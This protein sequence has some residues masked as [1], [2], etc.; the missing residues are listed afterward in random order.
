[1]KICTHCK[2]PKH[3]DEF[4]WKN[5]SKGTKQTHCKECQKLVSQKWYIENQ[6]KHSE[7]VKKNTKLYRKRNRDHIWNYLNTH[8]CIQCGEADPIV[9]EFDHRE[10][11]H[12][13][14]HIHELLSSSLEVLNEE[15]SKCDIRCANCH[16]RRTAL[17]LGWWLDKK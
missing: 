7:S 9:L 11:E 1:M 2:N 4:A 10:P 8:Q 14:C 5:K 6:R 13:K 16:R 15:I 3:D 12:K 17:Q